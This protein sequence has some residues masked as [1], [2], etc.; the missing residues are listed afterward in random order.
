MP[1]PS[2][3]QGASTNF[4][5]STSPA[6]LGVPGF[7]PGGPNNADWIPVID[8]II[9]TATNGVTANNVLTVSIEGVAVIRHNMALANTDYYFQDEFNGGYPIYTPG[10]GAAP[11]FTALES[12]TTADNLSYSIQGVGG[13]TSEAAAQSWTPANT[14]KFRYIDINIDKVGDP[15]DSLHLELR[16]TSPTGTLRATAGDLMGQSISTTKGY[17]RFTFVEPT[18][19]T[20]FG[21]KQYLVLTR[22][23]VRDTTNYYRWYGTNGNGYANGGAWSEQSGSWVALG[24]SA[25]DDLNFRNYNGYRVL[26]STP[27]TVTNNVMTVIFHHVPPSHIRDY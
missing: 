23:G 15:K 13:A 2:L 5:Q 11:A 1:Y 9:S 21:A 8:S 6:Y 27:N 14:Y 20:S 19:Q 4:T 12:Y 25:T 26:F 17:V 16:D 22:T 18:W 10:T 7:R 3:Y 24:E